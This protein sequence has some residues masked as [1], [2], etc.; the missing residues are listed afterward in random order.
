M[1]DIEHLL[2]VAAV[3]VLVISAFFAARHFLV[4][5]TF[6]KYGH[7]RAAAATEMASMPLH[8]AGEPACLRCHPEQ[9]KA[10]AGAGHR[11]VHCESCHGALLAHAQNPK[12]VK[13]VKPKEAD[14]RA[15]CGICHARNI[16]RPAKFPQQDLAQH[17][18]GVACS[19][20][21]NPHNP[22]P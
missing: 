1:K 10:K 14:M 3:F 2:R 22:K 6:G 16:S 21:H 4:P 11:G 7:Y 18:P 13:A 17:N 19:Q 20:C 9:A 15:F 5:E 12:A 8:Y